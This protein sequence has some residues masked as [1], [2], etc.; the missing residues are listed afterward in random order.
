MKDPL[1]APLPPPP[2]PPRP[3]LPPL[4]PTPPPPHTTRSEGVSLPVAM[5]WRTKNAVS[6]VPN[7]VRLVGV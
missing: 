5:D 7:E 2:R 6:A 1:S 4:P 3:P